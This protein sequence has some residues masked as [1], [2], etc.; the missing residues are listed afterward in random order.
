M[1][2][3]NFEKQMLR[4]QEIVDQLEKENIDLDKSISL[5][6]EGIEISKSLKKQLNQFEDKINVLNEVDNG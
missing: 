5:Y 1:A 4:L 6:E 2:K 3:Q